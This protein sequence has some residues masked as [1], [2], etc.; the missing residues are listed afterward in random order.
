MCFQ[1]NGLESHL[2]S[3]A[4]G[5][6]A[7]AKAAADQP[8]LPHCEKP[9]FLLRC[10]CLAQVTLGRPNLSCS[11]AA[12]K[13]LASFL[14]TL[15]LK[16]L[17][18]KHRHARSVKSTFGI[19]CYDVCD[20]LKE[21]GK[22]FG[23]MTKCQR[24]NWAS[25]TDQECWHMCTFFLI[26]FLQQR[27]D[28]SIDTNEQWRLLSKINAR[29]RWWLDCNLEIVRG[30]LVYNCFSCPTLAPLDKATCQTVSSAGCVAE[31]CGFV[32]LDSWRRWCWLS[33]DRDDSKRSKTQKH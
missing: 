33:L 27:S 19:I 14:H 24:L 2:E 22:S 6:G 18:L 25:C 9:G 31:L 11:V 8:G 1:C 5:C 16:R 29:I 15:L 30:I 28:S 13:A 17:E 32:S 26:F 3:L 20:F 23:Q 21:Y 4:A 7:R 12:P 10:N